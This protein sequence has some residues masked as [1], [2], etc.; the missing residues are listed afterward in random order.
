VKKQRGHGRAHEPNRLKK[1]RPN[2]ALN[3]NLDDVLLN[4][5]FDIALRAFLQEIIPAD[6]KRKIVDAAFNV[7]KDPESGM[8]Q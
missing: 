7:N 4:N 5:L 2:P 6:I 1:F 8:V 3:G